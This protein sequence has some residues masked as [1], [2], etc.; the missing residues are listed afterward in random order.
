MLRWIAENK[1]WLFSGLGLTVLGSIWWLIKSGYSRW[2]E[3]R[4][5]GTTVGLGI[6]WRPIQYERIMRKGLVDK[7]PSFI[8]RAAFKPEGVA[9]Q[10]GAMIVS[11][12]P[13]EVD[14]NIVS[15]WHFHR[16]ASFEFLR[17]QQGIS[18]TNKRKNLSPLLVR[19]F[20]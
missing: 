10:I 3:R 12:R 18:G 5:I 9:S 14:E 16:I 15:M 8:L 7:L 13:T 19:I 1:A 11:Q 2:M 6:G 20:S 4:A 17:S